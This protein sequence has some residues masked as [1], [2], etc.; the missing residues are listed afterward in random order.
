MRMNIGNTERL[1]RVVAG[2]GILSLTVVGPRSPWGFVG[3]LPFVTGLIGWCPPYTL[4]GIS[5][6][7]PRRTAKDP[8]PGAMSKV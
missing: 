1:I 5:T 7:K 3:L 4:L 6:R 2:I 8:A